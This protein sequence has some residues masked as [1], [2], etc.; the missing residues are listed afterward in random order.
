MDYGLR[1]CIKTYSFGDRFAVSAFSRASNN[2]LAQTNLSGYYFSFGIESTAYAFK[3][4]PSDRVIL[5]RLVDW[6]CACWR[7]TSSQFDATTLASLP[8]AFLRRA[9]GRF[10]EL[11]CMNNLELWK[12]RCYLEHSS[13]EEKASCEKLHMCYD[14]K[15]DTATFK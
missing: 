5:Q 6:Y 7:A 8:D 10:C 14:E 13:H 11:K 9:M 12:S 4:I 1:E 2:A 15:H 3:N